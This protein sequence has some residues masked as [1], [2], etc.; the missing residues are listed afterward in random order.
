MDIVRFSASPRSR[1]RH[2]LAHLGEG[3]GKVVR[4]ASGK[5]RDRAEIAVEHPAHMPG[6]FRMS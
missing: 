3:R 6:N 4:I 5:S 1:A 2:A